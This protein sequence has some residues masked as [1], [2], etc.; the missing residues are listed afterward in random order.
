MRSFCG[1]AME[2]KIKADQERMA[3]PNPKVVL[4]AAAFYL[5][6]TMLIFWPVSLNLSSKIANANGNYDSYQSLWG[7]WW[8]GYSIFTLHSSPYSTNMIF[9]P[10]GANLAT[11]TFEPISGLLS[12]P[13]QHIN[14]IL[15]YNF[16]FL[17]G[18]ALSGLF[19]YLLV[20]YLSRDNYA[21]FIAGI[22]F[23]FSSSHIAQAYAHLQ[24]AN[25]EWFPIFLLFFLLSIKRAR[26]LYLLGTSASFVLILFMGDLEQGI[27]ASLSIL[28][29]I[30]F[31]IFGGGLRKDILTKNFIYTLFK[32][33]LLILVISSPFII[34]IISSILYHNALSSANEASGITNN[35]AWSDNILSFFLPSYF[36]GFFSGMASSYLKIISPYGDEW[37]NISYIGYTVMGLCILGIYYDYKTSNLSRL[38][39]WISLSALFFLLSIG[40]MIRIGLMQTGIPGI[41][42]ILKYIPILGLVREPGRFDIFLSLFIAIISSFGMLSILKSSSAR[43][44]VTITAILSFLIIIECAGIPMTSN[45]IKSFFTNPSIPLIYR[46]VS[47]GA[48]GILIMPAAPVGS[49]YSALSMYY[50]TAFKKPIL[51][52]YATRT[53]ASQ[54]FYLYSI[55]L[56][57]QYIPYGENYSQTSRYPI[58]GNF[59]LIDNVLLDK[60]NVSSIIVMKN[61]YNATELNSLSSALSLLGTKT[62]QNG[63]VVE[64]NMD[65]YDQN[66]ISQNDSVSFLSGVWMPGMYFCNPQCNSTTLSTWWLLNGSSID[67]YSGSNRSLEMNYSYY[68]LLRTNLTLTINGN[69]TESKSITKMAGNSTFSIS[70]HTGLNVLSFGVNA[71]NS[72]KT[73][74]MGLSKIR[75]E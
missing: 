43:K 14:L 30:Y 59:M 54:E 22:I 57:S 9:Y 24:W 61:A 39:L 8:V 50:Q 68:S 40:P 1:A 35:I 62:Y 32:I 51:G 23:S 47:P 65:H 72:K 52:G 49:Q 25:I 16:V 17:L 3:F 55:P 15:A 33:T 37:E 6:I 38:G 73:F 29:L 70:I 12:L 13:F 26:P 4:I 60:Y 58:S 45:F 67:I 11:Q 42:L 46:S 74:Y 19:T 66:S 10:I 21:S 63:S 7:L 44:R 20:Y 28:A 31:G 5:L 69:L 41:Y 34:P 56:F 71:P 2:F 53:N 18:F 75:F 36:N 48:N 27:I 64:F